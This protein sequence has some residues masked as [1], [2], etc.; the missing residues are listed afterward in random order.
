[1]RLSAK[2]NTTRKRRPL[3]KGQV[4]KT[5]DFHVQIVDLGNILV[6]YKLVKDL[7]Q[8]R[9]TQMSRIENMEDYLRTNKARLV[10]DPR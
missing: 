1:M 3:A 10:E 7:G 8:M 6:H 5:K 4:W 9:R 2:K